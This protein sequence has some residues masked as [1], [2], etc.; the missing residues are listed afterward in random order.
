MV[1]SSVRH[2]CGALAIL[3]FIIVVGATRAEAQSAGRPVEVGG[4]VNILRLSEFESTDA[5]IGATAA[6]HLSPRLAID[7]TLAWFPGERDFE[8]DGL[9]TQGRVLGLVGA[10]SGITRGRVDIFGRART[11]FLRFAEQDDA[12]CALIFPATLGCRLASGY[13]AF[14]FDI[15]AGAIARL[16]SADRWQARIDVGDLLVRYN[17]DALRPNG[18]MTE[19]FVSHNLLVSFGLVWRF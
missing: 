17:L 1:V 7:G 5:G 4:Q 16:D 19:G 3:S 2:Q 18:E 9:A 11:G 8:A 10:R 6:W 15:G 12:I 14:A 13:T